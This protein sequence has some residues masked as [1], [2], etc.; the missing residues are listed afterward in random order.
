[1][2]SWMGGDGYHPVDPVK[3]VTTTLSSRLA[4]PGPLTHLCLGVLSL[5]LF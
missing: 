3:P 4:I 2:G 5:L 1:M